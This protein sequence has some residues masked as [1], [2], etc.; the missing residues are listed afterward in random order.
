M[1]HAARVA[2]TCRLTALR[3]YPPPALIMRKL[4]GSALSEARIVSRRSML[5]LS[6]TLAAGLGMRKLQAAE[7]TPPKSASD[8][9]AKIR[10]ILKDYEATWVFT[11]DSITHGA[12]H[13]YG[14]RSYVEL[15]AERLRWEMERPKH[16]VINTGISGE[17]CE[18]LLKDIKPR[19]LRFEPNVVSVMIGMNDAL[20][21]Q[22]GREPFRKRL[23]QLVLQIQNSGAVALLNT[24]NTIYVKKAPE[25]ADVSAYAAMVREVAAA[26]SAPLVDH[27]EAWQR[28]KPNQEDLL[29][30]LADERIHPGVY[31]HRALAHE[32]FR[33]LDMFDSDSPTCKLEVP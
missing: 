16:F 19:I 11:G 14:W 30:W 22:A 29:P 18:G 13:T 24:P 27:Y 4:I 20:N 25:R 21:G 23:S 3:T 10:D 1:E 5:G 33:R 6:A 9:L 7:Q 2:Y 31:G 8:G 17:R 26:T 32:I 28:A 12:L 15:F